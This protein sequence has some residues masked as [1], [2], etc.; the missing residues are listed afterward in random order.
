MSISNIAR[1]HSNRI[2]GT[3]SIAAMG[4][5]R[6]E[7][8]EPET[9]PGYIIKDSDREYTNK[10]DIV[11][12]TPDGKP[13]TQ[14]YAAKMMQTAR[15]NCRRAFTEYSHKGHEFIYCNFGNAKFDWQEHF[16]R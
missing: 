15:S 7:T 5:N 10:S 13:T 8:G 16:K 4:L 12:L 9:A 3:N 14:T 2:A 1:A 11:Y 6:L